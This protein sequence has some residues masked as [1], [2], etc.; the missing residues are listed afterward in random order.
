MRI[1]MDVCCL[2]RPFDDLSQ[3]QIYLEAE[4]VLSIL[5][6]CEKGDWTLLASGVIEYELSKVPDDNI[7][8]QIQILYA[9]AAERVSLTEDVE[10]RAAYFQENG[11]KP[12]DSLHLAIAESSGADVFLTTDNRL[13]RTVKRLDLSIKAANP[14]TWL[15]E[16]LNDAK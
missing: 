11:A 13:L 15:M 10:K 8:E 6:R 3:D 12:F 9:V 14:V 5:S 7:H 16:E 4:A 2:S 1:Y